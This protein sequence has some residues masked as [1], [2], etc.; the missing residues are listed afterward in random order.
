MKKSIRTVFAALVLGAFLIIPILSYATG[1]V[2]YTVKDPLAG[3]SRVI[4]FS[5][6]GDSAAGTVPNTST[7]VGETAGYWLCAMETDP[8]ATAPTALYDITILSA[9]GAD[10]LGGA[11]ANRSATVTEIAYPTIDSTSGQK[12]CVPI[13][14]AL[15]L[16][17]GNT[18]VNSATIEIKLFLVK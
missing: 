13:N 14:S 17:V 11:G 9:N 4:T 2:T 16:T 8:G 1:T 6:T 18:S 12:G 3:V 7:T 5:V 10:L 15:T